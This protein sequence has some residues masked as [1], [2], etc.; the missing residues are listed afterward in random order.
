MKSTKQATREGHVLEVFLWDNLQVLSVKRFLTSDTNDPSLRFHALQLYPQASL[1]SQSR[2]L[3]LQLSEGPQ[4][5]A[6]ETTIPI[7]SE[8]IQIC[9]GMDGNIH[10]LVKKRNKDIEKIA[11]V[12]N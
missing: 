9:N 11:D 5:A 12:H 6:T 2:S 10:M 4:L 8:S 1:S 7:S 3:G